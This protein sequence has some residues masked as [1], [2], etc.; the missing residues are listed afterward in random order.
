MSLDQLAPDEPLSP[1]L[2]LVFTPALRAQALAGLPAPVW[3]T[4]RRRPLAAPSPPAGGPAERSLGEMLVVR[5]A[6][7][8]LIFVAVTI[9]TLAM[10]LV[11]QAVR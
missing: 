7:L 6:H 9:L 10:S 1:E 8:A 3:A 5:V 2:V 11:A 4:T